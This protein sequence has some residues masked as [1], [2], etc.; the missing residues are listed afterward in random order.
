MPLGHR[1]DHI[2][3]HGRRCKDASSIKILIGRHL[4]FLDFQQVLAQRAMEGQGS[5]TLELGFRV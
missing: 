4:H 5:A 2:Y 3:Q 1:W